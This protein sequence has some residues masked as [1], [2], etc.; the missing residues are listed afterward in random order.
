MKF[1]HFISKNIPGIIFLLTMIYIFFYRW[2][3]KGYLNCRTKKLYKREKDNNDQKYLT[4]RCL[5]DGDEKYRDYI[6]LVEKE[7][8]RKRFYRIV[9]LYT[10]SQLG[11]PRP[12][13]DN[14][15]CFS[16]NK[17][18]SKYILSDEIK[19]YNILSDIKEILNIKD[20]FEGK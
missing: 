20:K 18:D 3:Y 15:K 6:Y 14:D 5:E 13:R 8:D 4:Q 17:E 7:G 9:D 11:Y 12:S 19:I 10:L 16:I 2:L 1:I